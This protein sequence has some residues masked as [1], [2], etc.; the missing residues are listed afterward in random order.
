[1]NEQNFPQSNESIQSSKNIWITIVAVIITALVV[2]G[3]VYVWQR[4]TIKNTEQGLQQQIDTLENQMKLLQ[5]SKSQDN[6]TTSPLTEI[7]TDKT[8]TSSSLTSIDQTWD[9][10]T[11][12]KYGFSIK[13]PK[14]MF[15]GYGSMCEWKTDSYRPKGGIVPV[16]IFEDENVYISSEYFYELTGET[17]K[18]SIH[19][20]SGCDKVINSLSY[21]KDDK[22]FQQQSWEFVIRDISNDIELE[23]FIK[24][25]YGSGCKLGSQNP[26]N[27]SDV[28]DISIQ[29]D[30][31]DLEE[32]KCPLNYMTVLKY[33]PEKN[34][35]VS[36]HLGQAT[37]FVADESYQNVYDQKMVESFKF[38]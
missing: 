37:T 17:V 22:Y 4:S 27:Q 9:L 12:H 14:K 1:M 38:E 33:Y 23:N 30:G 28:F 21:L 24:E 19:Y 3:G 10:Y 35:A 36:W 6:D 26:S 15:H 8:E 11:N 13:V 32:T 18:N 34:I 16:K 25:H 29:G 20:Y 31:K 5:Q 7:D 2:G